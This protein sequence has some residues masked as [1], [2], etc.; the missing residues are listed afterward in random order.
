MGHPQKSRLHRPWQNDNS[1]AGRL[2]KSIRSSSLI[3]M[4]QSLAT[5]QLQ[6]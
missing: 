5:R 3:V 6:M 4:L 1:P 2:E